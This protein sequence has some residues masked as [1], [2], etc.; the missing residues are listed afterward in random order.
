MLL[1][2]IPWLVLYTLTP[3][4]CWGPYIW[5]AKLGGLVSCSGRG[6][7]YKNSTPHALPFCL[8]QGLIHTPLPASFLH[9]LSDDADVL[10]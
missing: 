4:P 9:G 3:K 5:K 2:C 8:S 6:A 1:E 10:P 7:G